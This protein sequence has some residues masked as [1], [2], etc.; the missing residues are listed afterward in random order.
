MTDEKDSLRI[1]LK[2]EGVDKT[3]PLPDAHDTLFNE[4][5][6]MQIRYPIKPLSSPCTKIYSKRKSN[7]AFDITGEG[8]TEINPL[9][10]QT[11]SQR[12]LL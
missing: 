8:G 12:I 1:S 4:S 5:S 6:N 9:S 3:F 7:K 2:A 11:D 10:L